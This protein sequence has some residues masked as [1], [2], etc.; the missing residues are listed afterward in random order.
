[1]KGR[2]TETQAVALATREFLKTGAKLEEYRV[3]VESCPDG[4][5]GMVSFDPTSSPRAPGGG[6][7]VTVD[8][9]SGAVFAGYDD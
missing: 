7:F 3:T 9:E 1:M 2:F 6:V 8:K 4:K 5:T